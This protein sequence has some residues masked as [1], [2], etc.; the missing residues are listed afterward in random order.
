MENNKAFVFI[1]GGNFYFELKELR[2]KLN[3]RYSLLSFRFGDFSKLLVGDDELIETRYYI[4][5]IKGQL[6]NN[7]S[8]DI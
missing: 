8:L 7:I 4:G 5:A 1:D 2:A 6:N 3:E